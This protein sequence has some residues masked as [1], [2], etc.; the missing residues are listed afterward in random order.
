VIVILKYEVMEEEIKSIGI[1]I[2]NLLLPSFPTAPRSEG[3]T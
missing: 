2:A 1:N 3:T